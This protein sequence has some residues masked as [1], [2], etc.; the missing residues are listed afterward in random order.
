MIV[1][2][3]TTTNARGRKQRLV[4]PPKNKSNELDVDYLRALKVIDQTCRQQDTIS[5]IAEKTPGRSDAVKQK[6]SKSF[7][8]LSSTLTPIGQEAMIKTYEDT[9]VSHLTNVYSSKRIGTILP[10]LH[11]ATFRHRLPI[12]KNSNQNHVDN[13]H[14]AQNLIDNIFNSDSQKEEILCDYVRWQQQWT[15]NFV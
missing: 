7:N 2:A 3:T 6:K 15:K 8:Q 14:R 4:L 11:T 9:L 12:I 5:T 10:R 1:R 13:I